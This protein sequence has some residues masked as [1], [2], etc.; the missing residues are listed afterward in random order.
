MSSIIYRT[1]DTNSDYTFGLGNQQG[2]LTDTAAVA[3][4]IKTSLLL[5]QAEWWLDLTAGLPLWQDILGSRN[6]TQYITLLIQ[7]VILGVPYVQ[8]ITSISSTFDHTT[9]QFTFQA[10]V[11]TSF[12]TQITVSNLP[13]TL[14]PV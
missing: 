2:F 9:R 3:Q 10:T 1:L 14:P 13:V 7:E 12:S 8:A 4:A 11:T 5:F 6:N